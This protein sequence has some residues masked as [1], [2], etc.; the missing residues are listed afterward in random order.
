M[1]AEQEPSLPNIEIRNEQAHDQVQDFGLSE[2]KK[3]RLSRTPSANSEG[4]DLTHSE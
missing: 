2:S 1:K 4:I 3:Q